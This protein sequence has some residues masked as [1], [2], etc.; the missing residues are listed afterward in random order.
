[1]KCQELWNLL[2]VE[3][4]LW[5]TNSTQELNVLCTEKMKVE[6]LDLSLV[7]VCFGMVLSL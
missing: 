3:C 7:L 1:M 4:I 2:V 5:K 6:I